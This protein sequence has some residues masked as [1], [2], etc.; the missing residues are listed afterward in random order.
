MFILGYQLNGL[1]S[2]YKTGSLINQC[3]SKCVPVLQ[4]LTWMSSSNIFPL[5]KQNATNSNVSP[6]LTAWEVTNSP[7]ADGAD[8]SKV[9][10][11]TSERVPPSEPW[12]WSPLWLLGARPPA[13]V[14]SHLST[15][16]KNTLTVSQCPCLWPW[17]K[18]LLSTVSDPLRNRSCTSPHS[19]LG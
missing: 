12:L 1:G 3:F 4:A 17:C 6:N 10:P 19:G 11:A 15:E 9:S 14:P 7:D 5:K 8:L 16:Y 2:V 13:R 18:Q